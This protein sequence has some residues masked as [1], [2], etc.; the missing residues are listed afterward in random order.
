MGAPERQPGICF[1]FFRRLA[2]DADLRFLVVAAI[3]REHASRR[4]NDV[5]AHSFGDLCGRLFGFDRCFFG[6]AHFDELVG[7]QLLAQLSDDSLGDPELSDLYQ[8]LE[9]MSLAAQEAALSAS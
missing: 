4:L 8:R 1:A 3:Q 9:V 7:E 2:R 5:A 6:E